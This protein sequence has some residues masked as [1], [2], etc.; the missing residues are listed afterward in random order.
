[1][2]KVKRTFRRPSAK[3]LPNLSFRFTQSNNSRR[4]LPTEEIGQVKIEGDHMLRNSVR[5]SP[6][7]LLY[8][9]A[10]IVAAT[11]TTLEIPPGDDFWFIALVVLA[12][13]ISLALILIYPVVSASLFGFADSPSAANTSVLHGL[14]FVLF[15]ALLAYA[16]MLAIQS[17]ARSIRRDRARR[18]A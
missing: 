5:P 13:P 7:G 14:M 6:L 8:V 11:S 3:G 15:S 16:Q 10:C 9:A 2:L 1:M 12:F 17:F 18:Q 4:N